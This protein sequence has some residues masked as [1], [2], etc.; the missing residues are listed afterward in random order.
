M[1]FLGG[2]MLL[3]SAALLA[4][5][6]NFTRLSAEYQNG[7]T[8]GAEVATSAVPLAG[9]AGGI[10]TY[11]KVLKVGEDTDV[12]YL[13]FEGQADVHNGSALLLTATLT[14]GATTAVIQP[15]AGG[16][17]GSAGPAGWQTVL[18]LPAPTA[19]TNCHD[20]G[21]GGGD[22][23][24]NGISLSGCWRLQKPKGEGSRTVEV[25]IRLAD[26]PG[27]DGNVAFYERAFIAIDAQSDKEGS[28]G[29]LCSGVGTAKH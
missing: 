13:H 12:I 9:G 2:T 22:C 19:S 16:G 17:N 26:L 7:A 21:G 5:D 15:A 6:G 23:H 28:T 14:D 10:V 3:T 24:D 8:V 18:K 1:L 29:T 4:D 20:G 11:D 27:G 25:K